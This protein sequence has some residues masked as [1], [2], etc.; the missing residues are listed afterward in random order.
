M[1]LKWQICFLRLWK[2]GFVGRCQNKRYSIVELK[3]KIERK[4]NIKPLLIFVSSVQLVYIVKQVSWS[5]DQDTCVTIYIFCDFLK[6]YVM[7]SDSAWLRISYFIPEPR[8]T[9]I[10]KRRP[11]LD[12]TSTT[13]NII[14]PMI[15][16]IVYCDSSVFLPKGNSQKTDTEKNHHNNSHNNK[17]K[18]RFFEHKQCVFNQTQTINHRA[19]LKSPVNIQTFA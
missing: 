6:M 2:N 7:H 17:I 8:L 15:I 4:K 1:L 19:T 13:V 14:T 18:N 10:V 11:V 12:V 3:I 16:T 5:M 9:R